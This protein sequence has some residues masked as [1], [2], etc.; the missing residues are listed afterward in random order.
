MLAWAHRLLMAFYVAAPP[1]AIAL[2]LIGRP[3]RRRWRALRIML[4][5][6]FVLGVCASIVYGVWLGGSVP[7]AQMALTCYWAAGLLCLLKLLDMAADQLA[8]ICLGVG[9]GSWHRSNRRSAAYV[10][11]VIA[12]FLI[13]LP[14]MMAAAATYRLGVIV[15]MDTGSL[16][17][18]SRQIQ[19]DSTDGLRLAGLWLPA[20]AAPNV[21]S[22]RWGRQTAIICPGPRAGLVGYP[23]LI[24]ELLRSGY[25]VFSFDFRGQGFSQ[26]H[27]V[28]FGDAERFDVLG[29][30]RWLREHQRPGAQRIV[31]IGMETG[32]AALLGAAADPGQ[33]G[34]AIAS[35]V[36]CAGFDRFDALAASAGS[37]YFIPPLQWL[38]EF[39]GVPMACLQ[40]GV[41]LRAFAP[42][43]DA[44]AVA[45]R[46]IMFVHG[47]Q[48]PIIHFEL[49]ERLYDAASQPKTY[50]W[51]NQTTADALED[52]QVIATIRKFL[53]TAVPM[54]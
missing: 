15:P 11:R 19:F 44:L 23:L 49:G 29:A 21:S 50:L 1:V 40:T 22:P 48:D 35:W 16:D 38:D 28:T 18:A 9:Y 37:E 4:A 30:V 6:W 43:V 42:A 10:I 2:I 36:I 47:R 53:D 46:P 8:R 3:S 24:D 12:V 39:I 31:G 20:A 33:D 51:P 26:G 14:Y 5:R 27:I 17:P 34:Q 25:N 54:L 41:D 13:G 45:P 52:S 7:I 32:A